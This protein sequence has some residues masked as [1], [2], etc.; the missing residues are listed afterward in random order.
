MKIDKHLLEEHNHMRK[1]MDLPLL[2]EQDIK[3]GQNQKISLECV[4]YNEKGEKGG[5]MP[6]NGQIQT[7]MREQ[8]E[9]PY[10]IVQRPQSRDDFYSGGGDS[11]AQSYN[12]FIEPIVEDSLLAQLGKYEAGKKILSHWPRNDSNQPKHYCEVIKDGTSAEF[13]QEL[14][15]NGVTVV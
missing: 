11:G 1:L 14:V 10:F 3:I 13:I 12:V 2:S 15:K 6:I 9:V 8:Y 5:N 7:E 4:S